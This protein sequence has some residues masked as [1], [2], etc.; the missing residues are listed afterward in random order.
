ML[1]DLVKAGKL[2][3]VD[4]RLPDNPMV[5]KP[6]KETGQYGGEM[7]IGFVGTSP[8]WGGMLYLAGWEHPVSWTYDFT[9]V[10]PNFAESLTGNTDASV[11][12]MKLRK[13][14]KW[15]DGVPFTADDIAFYIQ[16]V[17]MNKISTRVE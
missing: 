17:A 10:V 5:V 14:L 11:W 15:S 16:D 7:R 9:G 4:Q 12:T 3:P 2:P 1:A 6:V 8:E 13:G